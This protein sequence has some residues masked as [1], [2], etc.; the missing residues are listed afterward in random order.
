[1][2]VLTGHALVHAESCCF[3]H[4]Q[5]KFRKVFPTLEIQTQIHLGTVETRF[6]VVEIFKLNAGPDGINWEAI[7][8]DSSPPSFSRVDLTQ[9][10]RDICT[11]FPLFP[12]SQI[13]RQLLVSESYPKNSVVLC[14]HACACDLAVLAAAISDRSKVQQ[15]QHLL[16]KLQ[17]TNERLLCLTCVAYSHLG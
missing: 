10:E 6:Y 5:I 14:T 17:L 13:H 7:V 16:L 2:F 15:S 9:P 4:S 1:M 11:Q 3:Y 8:D 12:V